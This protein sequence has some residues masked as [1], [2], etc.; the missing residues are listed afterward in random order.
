[1]CDE[2]FV[3]YVDQVLLGLV[4]IGDNATEKDLRR[5]RHIGQMG[6][7]KP[8]RAGLGAGEGDAVLEQEPRE[9]GMMPEG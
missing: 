7:Q 4:G 6:A 8:A 2:L 3:G 1:M 9:L 5:S